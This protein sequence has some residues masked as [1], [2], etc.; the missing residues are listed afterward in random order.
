MRESTLTRSLVA[1]LLAALAV[2]P[3]PGQPAVALAQTQSA[4]PPPPVFGAQTAAVVVDF[5]VRDKKGK[6]VRDLSAADFTILEDGAP[7]KVESL[8][9]VD[10]APA[11]E[12]GAATAATPGAAPR[13]ETAAAATPAP[14]APT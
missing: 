4:T 5:V 10:T 11:A 14:T 9:V 8:R 7:Q 2:G 12:E 1:T 3:G 13:A 6:L